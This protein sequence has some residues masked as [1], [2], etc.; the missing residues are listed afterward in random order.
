MI[1]LFQ[2]KF[3]SCVIIYNTFFLLKK[4]VCDQSVSKCKVDKTCGFFIISIKG[5]KKL[6]FDL[7]LDLKKEEKV[8]KTYTYQVAEKPG[9]INH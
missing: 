9:K 1:N 6:I 7:N 2:N 3:T 5:H 4:R 8:Y